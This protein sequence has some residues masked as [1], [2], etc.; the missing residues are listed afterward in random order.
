MRC[1][2]R[3]TSRCGR[4]ATRAAS[5]NHCEPPGLVQRDVIRAL[6]P[7]HSP[8]GADVLQRPTFSVRMRAGVQQQTHL[9]HDARLV[10]GVAH[11]RNFCDLDQHAALAARHIPTL[12]FLLH[13]PPP[14]AH[15]ALQRHGRCH[16]TRRAQSKRAK[17]AA[18]SERSERAG[19]TAGGECGQSSVVVEGH[20]ASAASGVQEACE[21]SERR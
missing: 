7:E 2:I 18:P 5:K 13:C 4:D 16:C 19:L 20:A 17:R 10:S 15:V 14:L 1:T 6:V 21:R 8:K 9:T 11:R 3:C 12:V